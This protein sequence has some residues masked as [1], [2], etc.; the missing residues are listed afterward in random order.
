M[1]FS[2]RF[3]S[4]SLLSSVFAGPAL[5]DGAT[6][7]D[8]YFKMVE[9][10]DQP[11]VVDMSMDLVGQA[12]D[13]AYEGAD[14][15]VEWASNEAEMAY[16]EQIGLGWAINQWAMDMFDIEMHPET[17]EDFNEVFSF[18]FEKGAIKFKFGTDYDEV[19]GYLEIPYWPTSVNRDDMGSFDGN[20][21]ISGQMYSWQSHPMNEVINWEHWQP[22]KTCF[23]VNVDH[24]EK[25][26][27]FMDAA[28]GEFSGFAEIYFDVDY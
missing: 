8:E 4:L 18:D 2:K 24:G 3:Y 16:G 6:D 27:Y 20:R 14:M 19:S 23:E 12:W 5:M 28:T 17:I 26:N 10:G 9:G 1:A 11:K 15:A 22:V 7:R 21:K 13:A 25:Y